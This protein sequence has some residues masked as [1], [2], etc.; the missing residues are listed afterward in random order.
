MF[1]MDNAERKI[2]ARRN[3]LRIYNETG[4][5][6]K[7]ALRCGIARSTLYRWIKRSEEHSEPKLSDKPHRPNNLTNKKITL[8][9]EALILD[10]LEKQQVSEARINTHLHPSTKIEQWPG[11]DCP[12]PEI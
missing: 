6:T 5:V 2:I 1:C 7:T 8:E 3:W 4:S 10:I 9:L 11:T 12:V